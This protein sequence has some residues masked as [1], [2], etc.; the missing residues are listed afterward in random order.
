VR[1]VHSPFPTLWADYRRRGMPVRRR[2]SKGVVDSKECRIHEK[3]TEKRPTF[4]KKIA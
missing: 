2:G 4:Y 3:A 1:Q